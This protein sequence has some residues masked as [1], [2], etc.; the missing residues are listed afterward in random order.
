MEKKIVHWLMFASVALF[1][2]AIVMASV[3]R[4]S[5]DLLIFLAGRGSVALLVAALACF[6][7][8]KLTAKRSG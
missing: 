2:F 6:G 4:P 3:A 8:F 7:A 1:G 5:A